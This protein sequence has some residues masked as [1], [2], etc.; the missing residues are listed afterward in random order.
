MGIFSFFNFETLDFRSDIK[1]DS[2][3]HLANIKD[4]HLPCFHQG[5]APN[6]IGMV[7]LLGNLDLTLKPLP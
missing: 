4:Q 7:Q 6:H 1:Y 2:Y 3:K 5:S